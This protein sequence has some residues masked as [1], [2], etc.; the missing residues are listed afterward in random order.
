MRN[1]VEKTWPELAPLW[2]EFFD[3]NACATPYQSY[4]FL[5]LTGKGKPQRKDPFR[6]IGVKELNLVLYKDDEAIAIAPLLLKKKRGKH[7]VYFR[8]HFTTASNLDFL[9]KPGWTCDDFRF[10]MDG[11]RERLGNVS[12]LFDRICEKT[13][14]FRYM[15]DYFTEC[16]IEQHECVSIPIPSDYDDWL[17]GLRKSCRRNIVRH[18]NRLERENLNWRVEFYQG[19]AI[20]ANTYKKMMAVYANR[21][22]VK[23]NFRFGALTKLVTK[24]LLGILMRDKVTRFLNDCEASFHG[25]LFL[26][27][28]VAAFTSGLICRDRRIAFCRLA[29]NTKLAQYGP[30]VVLLSSTMKHIIEQNKKGLLHVEQMDLSEGTGGGMSYKYAFGGVGYYR[31]DFNQ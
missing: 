8:G 13:M 20:D 22:L 1:L 18:I 19:D 3:D 27:D 25:V 7:I 10:L 23:N 21:F 11:I 28:R 17:R 16:R 12:F 2:P 31:Y 26:N 4:E 5:T 24:I 9:Y 6:L 29:M 14:T 15:K 30:G